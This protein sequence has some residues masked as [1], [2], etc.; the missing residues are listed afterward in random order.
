VLGAADE[1]GIEGAPPETIARLAV[2]DLTPAELE[3]IVQ[4]W[5]EGRGYM[6]TL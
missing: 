2:E 5:L 1:V 3:G 4:D 6:G